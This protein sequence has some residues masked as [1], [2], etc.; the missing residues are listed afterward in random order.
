MPRNPTAILVDAKTDFSPYDLTDQTAHKL[1]K[2]VKQRFF[3][4]VVSIEWPTLLLFAGVYLGW[5]L[6]ISF[7]AML[8]VWVLLPALAFLTTLH[9][10][11]Q[12]EALHGHPTRSGVLNECLAAIPLG[13]FIPYR[14]FKRLHL[15]HHCDE[16]LT[17]PYDDPESFYLAQQDWMHLPIAM[18]SLLRAN[19][20]LLGRLTIGPALSLFAFYCS[21]LKLLTSVS[22]GRRGF[23]VAWAL[24]IAGLACVL[25]VL[26]AAE[27]P[28]WLYL[29]G[30][31]YATMSL[32]MLRTYAEHQAAEHVG[33]R[34][35]IV[36]ASPFFALLYLN[37][38]LHFVH[39]RFPG[40]PWY[41][42]P[43][44]YRRHY[45]PLNAQNGHYLIAGYWA[46]F[47][48]YFIRAKE[49]VAHPLRCSSV[50]QANT[51]D[52]ER[53]EPKTS[54]TVCAQDA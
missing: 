33:P 53:V 35:A 20:T 44:L 43:Q 39:H 31:A 6:A 18:R 42:L 9:S 28:I 30:V 23:G 4:P 10:S 46:L 8:P 13:L 29:F 24:H 27:F 22:K 47:R 5:V 52:P 40:A 50:S 3:A 34:T 49:P 11:L 48:M 45:S 16:N 12:H 38:N 51:H 1:T 37:N 41:R 2:R 14:R 32:L 36:E 26:I 21:E 54:A 19:N 25:A 7:H 15:R 17:D